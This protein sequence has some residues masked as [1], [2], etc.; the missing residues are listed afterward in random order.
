MC[1][2]G[3]RASNHEAGRRLLE[4]GAC[5]ATCYNPSTHEADPCCCRAFVG[6]PEVTRAPGGMATEIR[7]AV[8]PADA[9]Q[10]LFNALR[11][12]TALRDGAYARGD[13]A[14]GEAWERGVVAI[15]AAETEMKRAREAQTYDHGVQ[16]KR[17]PRGKEL[18][19]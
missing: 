11:I 5:R 4:R 6:R 3:H 2:C 8:H 9:D 18:T 15:H 10:A 19:S 17:P 14:G 13:T 12:A 16:I 7:P 1:T